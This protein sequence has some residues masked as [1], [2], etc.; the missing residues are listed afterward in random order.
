MT[1]SPQRPGPFTAELIVEPYLSGVRIDTFLA[2]H[3]RNY[4]SWRMMRMVRAGLAWVDDAPAAAEQRVF[5]GQRVRIRLVEPPDKLIG[6]QPGPLDVLYEDPWL[7]AVNKPAGQVVHPVADWQT[8]T[9]SNVLQGHFDR[10]AARPGLLRPGFVHRLDR[11]TSG[12]ILCAKEHLAHRR[13]SLQFQK[14][15]VRKAYVAL[16]EGVLESDHGTIDLPIG[17]RP[18]RRS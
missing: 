7:V 10:Q 11:E 5:R 1:S 9:L 2:R 18:G 16:V 12:V 8:E 4:T 3:F 13:L 14:N 17:R 6:P 15:R